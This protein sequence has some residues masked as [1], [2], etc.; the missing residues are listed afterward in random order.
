MRAIP[1]WALRECRDFLKESHE[2]GVR[3]DGLARLLAEIDRCLAPSRAVKAARLKRA[4]K[5]ATERSE[6]RSIYLAVAERSGGACECGCR[7]YA[8]VLL[9]LEL[10]HMLGGIGRRRTL[11]SKYTCWQLR[12]DCHQAKSAN[13]PSAAA[14][15]GRFIQHC[16]QYALETGDDGYLAAKHICQ[17]RLDALRIQGRTA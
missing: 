17:A 8:T 11:Q 7:R 9:P 1:K 15:L 12:R 5:K 13:N 2:H 10:E 4:E 3:P 14:W 6:I 16:D